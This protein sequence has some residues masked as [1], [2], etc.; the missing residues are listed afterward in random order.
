MKKVHRTDGVTTYIYGPDDQAATVM[1]VRNAV[2]RIEVMCRDI[3]TAITLLVELLPEE[4]G[5]SDES[6]D[7]HL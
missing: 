6:G 4:H 1:D 3:L 7:S 2:E 5:E